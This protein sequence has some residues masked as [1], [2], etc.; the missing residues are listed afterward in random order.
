MMI[1]TVECNGSSKH[2]LADKNRQANTVAME[3]WAWEIA[4]Y[5]KRLRLHN[6]VVNLEADNRIMEGSPIMGGN[7]TIPM[8]PLMPHPTTVVRVSSEE[9]AQIMIWIVIISS[10]W[11]R[12]SSRQT[13]RTTRGKNQRRLPSNYSTIISS[14]RRRRHLVKMEVGMM[15]SNI[16][17]TTISLELACSSSNTRTVIK[18]GN[19]DQQRAQAHS[20]LWSTPEIHQVENH[21]LLSD[22]PFD[23]L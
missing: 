17:R 14:L 22:T 13:M 2:L 12:N 8:Q 20:P 16:R 21:Q 10:Q 1:Q 3:A 6:L 19:R 9:E 23:E 5:K 4:T 15:I 11:N 7:P 18:T